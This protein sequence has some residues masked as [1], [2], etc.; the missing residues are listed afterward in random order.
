V[1]SK[2]PRKPH[3]A[4]EARNLAPLDLIHS[5]LCE[6]NGILTKGSI[7]YFITFIDDSTRFCYVY[8]LMSKGEALRY[9]KTYKAEVENQ[10]ERKIKRLRSDR[11]GEYFSG[12]FSDFCV[13][14][15]II[16]ERTPPYSPQSNGVAERKNNTLTDLVNAML[17]TSGL[18]K[19]WWGEAILMVCHVMNKV[20]TKNK[21]ITPFEE[22][23]K[24]KLNI[25]YLRTWGC[26]AKVNVPINKKRKLGPKTVDYVFLGYAFHS[27]GYRFLIINFGVPNMLVGTIMESRDAMFFEDKF[28]MKATHN[29]SSDEPTIPH[30]HFI[31]VEHTEESHIHNPMEANSISTRKSKR[32]RI[33]KFFGDDY[34]V[35]LVDDTPSTIE[36]AYSSPDADFWKEAIRSEM[37]SIMSNATWEV[38]ER[39]YGCKPI[40]SK[41][42]F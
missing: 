37:D 28:P 7:R 40:G 22:R 17:E 11:G 23:E 39:P 27:I 12:D 29:T 32:P 10:L 30:E 6:M 5:N 33:A 42:V 31:P 18:S 13:E 25:S 9:F 21:E 14:H 3:K 8:L 36:E 26:L 20:P 1:Q 24:R 16:H 35:Y 41:W 15:D 38:V 34:I 4:T 19:E 2:Q